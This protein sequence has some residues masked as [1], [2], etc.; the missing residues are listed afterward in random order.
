MTQI[1]AAPLVAIPGL[2]FNLV[3]SYGDAGTVTN[4]RVAGGAISDVAD[5]VKIRQMIMNDGEAHGA[6]ALST[7]S[8]NTLRTNQIAGRIVRYSP[9]DSSLYPGYTFGFFISDESLHPGSAGPEFSDPGLFGPT[10]WIDDDLDDGAVLLISK[11]QSPGT[12]MWNA[13][14]PRII[15]TLKNA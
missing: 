9:A 15:A 3:F 5:C 1:A 14:R 6:T 8:A 10:P 12:A 4:P 13:V 11:D 7:R 2:V